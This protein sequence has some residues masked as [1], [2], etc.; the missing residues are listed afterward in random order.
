[1]QTYIT[2]PPSSMRRAASVALLALLALMLAACGSG[3]DVAA[4]G[5]GQA[6]PAADE[7]PISTTGASPAVY[8]AESLRPSVV[9]V[10]VADAQRQAQGLGSA[11]CTVQRRDS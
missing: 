10:S 4:T 7:A 8:V 1:M 11:S 2:I 3:G 5:G 9:D 6:S